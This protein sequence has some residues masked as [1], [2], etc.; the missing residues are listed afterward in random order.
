MNFYLGFLIVSVSQ[1][2]FCASYFPV[3]P[4][5]IPHHL[6]GSSPQLESCC[7]NQF[8]SGTTVSGLMKV[9]VRR[10]EGRDNVNLG[11][12]GIYTEKYG[13]FFALV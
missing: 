12:L 13:N 7:V 3:S 2:H 1:I 8:S 11:H 10:E 9:A 4:A 6:A 5:V